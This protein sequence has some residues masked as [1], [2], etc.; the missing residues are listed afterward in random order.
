LRIV[1]RKNMTAGQY[2]QNHRRENRLG[3]H[4]SAFTPPASCISNTC[5]GKIAGGVSESAK[6]G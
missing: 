2:A 3:L 4:Y 1:A 6:L 5:K